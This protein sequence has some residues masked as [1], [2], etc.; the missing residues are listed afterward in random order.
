[1][2]ADA[3]FFLRCH[4]IRSITNIQ[5]LFAHDQ[6]QR[7]W[8]AGRTNH[9]GLYWFLAFIFVSQFIFDMR[10]AKTTSQ[11]ANHFFRPIFTRAAL[12][13]FEKKPSSF[14]RKPKLPLCSEILNVF[15]L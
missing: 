10:K 14:K 9:A 11:F 4:W 7:T 2:G 13:R 8:H 12:L 3:I 5:K 1:M 15:G 6:G